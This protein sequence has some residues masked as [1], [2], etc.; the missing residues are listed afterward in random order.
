MN[1]QEFLAVDLKD[2]ELFWVLLYTEF[3]S[4]FYEKFQVTSMYVTNVE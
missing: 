2:L 4:D 3:L 1:K